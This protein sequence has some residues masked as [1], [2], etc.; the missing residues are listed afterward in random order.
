METK[1]V[2]KLPIINKG[3]IVSI[4][5]TII[6]LES[7]KKAIDEEIESFKEDDMRP[8]VNTSYINNTFKKCVQSLICESL[9]GKD[10]IRRIKFNISSPS[11][12]TLDSIDYNFAYIEPFEDM[13]P[14]FESLQ[15]ES[16][17]DHYKFGI[18]LKYIEVDDV[19]GLFFP[20]R[21]TVSA[22][23]FGKIELI[24]L[25]PKVMHSCNALY[26]SDFP[27]C[28]SKEIK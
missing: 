15:K 27:K 10:L 11:I 7:Y 14:Y 24:G 12:G 3:G 1:L 28:L 8:D 21:K 17:K 25:S 20:T 6:E 22:I 16:E 26:G 9:S 19:H 5:N 18:Y 2:Y 23:N 13:I 4:D